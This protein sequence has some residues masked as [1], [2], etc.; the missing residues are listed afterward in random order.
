MLFEA[1]D[2]IG[3]TLRKPDLNLL[4]LSHNGHC[5]AIFCLENLKYGF[6]NS[7]DVGQHN[8]LSVLFSGNRFKRFQWFPFK[9]LVQSHQRSPRVNTGPT[10]LLR[11]IHNI[12]PGG[13]NPKRVSRI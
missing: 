10:N 13:R 8:T 3:T 4:M 2:G 6:F 7:F 9:M 11:C 5:Y 12:P 1:E